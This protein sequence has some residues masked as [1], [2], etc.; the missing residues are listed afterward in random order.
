M[1]STR[2]AALVVALLVVAG[3]TWYFLTHHGTASSER[4]AVYYTKADGTSL[5]SWDVSMR[6]PQA[7]ESAEEHAHNAA[8]YAAVQAVAGP[9]SDVTAIR[10][11]VGTHVLG[12]SVTGST[13]TVD[14]SNEVSQQSGGSFGENG[15][16][17]GLVYTMTGLP[18]V[19]AVQVRV[20]GRKVDTLPG[21][22]L[23]LDMPLHRSDW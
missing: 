9:P 20:A 5:A 21:G 11:P 18:G 4:L 16:F 6:P 8:L 1:Q 13:A 7:G 12:V 22:H 14:L 3:G 17:K 2:V 15:E 10:F 19:S 23:E